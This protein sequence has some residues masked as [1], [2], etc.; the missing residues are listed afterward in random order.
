MDFASFFINQTLNFA[1]YELTPIEFKINFLETR[2]NAKQKLRKR[3]LFVD[4]N[5]GPETRPSA[6]FQ[7][8]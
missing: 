5:K 3:K 6:N 2:P 8:C 4:R 7:I 1:H